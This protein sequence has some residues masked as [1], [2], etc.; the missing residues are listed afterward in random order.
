MNGSKLKLSNE[1]FTYEYELQH[2]EPEKLR[3][4]Q[5]LETDLGR[6]EL[7]NLYTLL[8]R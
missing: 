5:A 6:L 2:L 1:E 7:N 4:S 3:D 8:K